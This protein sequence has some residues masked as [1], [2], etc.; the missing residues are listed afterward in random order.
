MANKINKDISGSVQEK[1]GAVSGNQLQGYRNAEKQ[2]QVDETGVAR[3]LGKILGQQSSQR[4][5]K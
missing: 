4:Y 3:R 2:S 5:E 1:K